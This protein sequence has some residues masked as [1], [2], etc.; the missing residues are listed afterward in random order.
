MFQRQFEKTDKMWRG[1]SIKTW[2]S[3]DFKF[4]NQWQFSF[5]FSTDNWFCSLSALLW[6]FY[7]SRHRFFL[8]AAC[9][10]IGGLFAVYFIFQR[11]K[12]SA[13]ISFM[14][15]CVCSMWIS[16]SSE[17]GEHRRDRQLLSGPG[18]Q[19]SEKSQKPA[20]IPKWMNNNFISTFFFS[21][22]FIAGT[23]FSL[24]GWH[25]YIHIWYWRNGEECSFHSTSPTG[26][27]EISSR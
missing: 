13:S 18:Q 21:S 5:E 15:N 1:F 9:S 20:L 16:A 10:H 24:Y 11:E 3:V 26:V 19:A 7:P 27:Y 2:F 25:S 14:E 23:L 17:H 8:V 22:G 12:A 4:S 6:L